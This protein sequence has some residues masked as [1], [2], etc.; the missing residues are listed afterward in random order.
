M[1]PLAGKG[2][3]NSG[4]N[5]IR[6]IKNTLGL[7]EDDNP[8]K[9]QV[10]ALKEGIY[11]YSKVRLALI[12]SINEK[13]AQAIEN[14]ALDD[15][16]ENDIDEYPRKSERSERDRD[17]DRDNWKDTYIKEYFGSSS[18]INENDSDPFIL[19]DELRSA[20]K[21]R[22]GIAGIFE[23]YKVG[24][25]R[26]NTVYEAA[27]SAYAAVQNSEFG[28]TYRS[29]QIRGYRDNYIK[30]KKL[31]NNFYVSYKFLAPEEAESIINGSLSDEKELFA[32]LV[33]RNGFSLRWSVSSSLMNI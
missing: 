8:T 1:F 5:P 20:D 13:R 9:P 31:L 17:R 28:K 33:K 23:K 25:G 29:R 14:L 4:H 21:I 12:K 10:M 16:E 27:R 24:F 2:E 6:I 3:N 26:V 22:D 32:L 15:E 11:P 18:P 30:N 19:E 7:S